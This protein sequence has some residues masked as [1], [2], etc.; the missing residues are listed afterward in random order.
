[1]TISSLDISFDHLFRLSTLSDQAVNVSNADDFAL[2]SYPRSLSYHRCCPCPSPHQATNVSSLDQSTD[3]YSC[4]TSLFTS[5]QTSVGADTFWSH[6]P[7]P[8]HSYNSC[9]CLDIA[10]SLK[11]MNQELL[12]PKDWLLLTV[13]DL[14]KKFAELPTIDTSMIGAAPFN[15]L[16]QP[17]S[18]AQNME[19]FSIPI[20][21]IEKALASKST[22]DLA[23]KLPTE[24]H[25]FLDV[26]S[27]ANSDILPPHRPYDHKI[28][29]ME[30]KTPS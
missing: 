17:A 19:I 6:N 27:Q 15:M 13:S 8:H 3:R 16:V 9:Y 14:L 21:D 2:D 26:F 11:T 20:Y 5:S 22:T 12:Q 29:L 1:M 24:Y 4:S 18:H 25:D 28:P 10:D 23:K 7:R 30:E